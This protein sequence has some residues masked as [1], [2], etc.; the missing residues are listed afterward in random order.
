MLTARFLLEIVYVINTI[1]N[2]ITGRDGPAG[3]AGPA[4]PNRLAVPAD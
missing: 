2:I 4:D 3:T 1:K